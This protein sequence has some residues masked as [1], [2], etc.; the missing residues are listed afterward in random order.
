MEAD[1]AGRKE[2][3]TGAAWSCRLPSCPY[4]SSVPTLAPHRFAI[5]RTE[6][7]SES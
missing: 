7:R 2:N 3:S 6:Y 4:S 1:K 5:S